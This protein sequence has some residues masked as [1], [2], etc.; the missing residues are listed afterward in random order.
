MTARARA[1]SRQRGIFPLPV[2]SPHSSGCVGGRTSRSVTRRK[3]SEL[4]VERWVRDMVITLNCLYSG[5]E[6]KGNFD[7]TSG[8]PT[9]AQSCCLDRLYGA[10]R[11]VGKPP[12]GLDG[13]EPSMSFGRARDTRLNPPPWLHSR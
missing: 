5:D 8:R 2:P 6:G 7:G 10:V 11:A 3:L 1:V 13:P 4:H 9:A 12:P